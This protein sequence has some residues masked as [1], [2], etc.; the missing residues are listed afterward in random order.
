MLLLTDSSG[1]FIKAFDEDVNADIIK[2]L[3]KSF[4]DK[5]VELHTYNLDA[6]DLRHISAVATPISRNYVTYLV[7][8]KKV[9]QQ[10]TYISCILNTKYQ[11]VKD[12]ITRKCLDVFDTIRNTVIQRYRLW[13]PVKEDD[14]VEGGDDHVAGGAAGDVGT[15]DVVGDVDT[16]GVAGDVGTGGVVGI[17]GEVTMGVVENIVGT[18]GG[19]NIMIPEAIQA[20][21][22]PLP[23]MVNINNTQPDI[24]NNHFLMSSCYTDLYDPG[25]QE[26]VYNQDGYP[27]TFKRNKLQ[28]SYHTYTAVNKVDTKEIT[29]N[30]TTDGVILVRY[31]KNIGFEPHYLVFDEDLHN[32]IGNLDKYGIH[33]IIIDDII[34]YPKYDKDYILT[35]AKEASTADLNKY[36][37]TSYRIR[38]SIKERVIYGKL[39]KLVLEYMYAKYKYA[40]IDTGVDIKKVYNNFDEYNTELFRFYV[41]DLIP[42]P[43]FMQ[44]LIY[45]GYN[46]KNGNVSNIELR[47]DKVNVN[48]D[49]SMSIEQAYHYTHRVFRNKKNIDLR[50]VP[51]TQP[52]SIISPWLNSEVLLS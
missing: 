37:L 42:F 17:V 6:D 24:F 29:D 11:R 13:Y 47:K 31:F 19:D 28:L 3:Y 25:M 2:K 34:R 36:I 46:I 15:G 52:S 4:L 10:Y 26:D 21:F 49:V 12:E 44:I 23:G 30:Q 45:L 14:N 50:K 38:K 43:T 51:F 18:N 7:Y 20:E 32:E 1:Y 9:L 27:V 48:I 22:I 33:D 8:R 35:C 16:G 39:V 5:D 40:P 41:P